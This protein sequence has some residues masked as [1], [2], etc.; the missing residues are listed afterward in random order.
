MTRRWT[1]GRPMALLATMLLVGRLLP[2]R[3]AAEPAIPP[4]RERAIESLVMMEMAR[5]GIPGLALAIV[6]GSQVRLTLARGMADLENSVPA[7]VDTVFRLASLSKAITATAVM[8]LAERGQIDLDAPIQ[9][10]VPAFPEKPWPVTA[11]ELLC[12]Q[13][14][15]RHHTDAEWVNT[16][17]FETLTDSLSLFKDAPLAHEP[18]TRTL[19][20]SYGYSLLGCAVETASGMSFVDYLQ[21]NVFQPAGMERTQIDDHFD[22]VPGRASGYFRDASGRLR[23]SP[24]TDTSN[25]I[26]G[27]GLCGTVADV[28]RFAAAFQSGA[29]VK[30]ASVREML[31]AQRARNGKLTGYGL[32]WIV[33]LKKRGRE[34]WCTGA[35]PEVSACLFLR[36]DTQTA[37]V[38]M[39][40]LESVPDAL[41]ELAR[42]IADLVQS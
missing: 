18:G 10:Y 16:R 13:S 40:N 35:Q 11:R 28:A 37:V 5:H 33:S 31:S 14:G 12:H 26:P 29:L 39:C 32:G 8:Q 3:E 25:R 27:G 4:D 21:Q 30:P 24:L 22:V 7:R 38:L 2:A 17:H 15:I 1:L 34:V 41:V 36:L 20:S 42:R 19:Y 6:S 9:K 23:N